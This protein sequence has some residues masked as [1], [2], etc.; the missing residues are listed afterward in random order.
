M[1]FEDRQDLVGHNS[2]RMT[3]HYSEAEV[4]N[5]IEASNKICGDQSRKSPA[6]VILRKKRA[7]SV[8]ANMA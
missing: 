4:G 7:M 6:R 5:L 2:G 3:T 1:F 8:E